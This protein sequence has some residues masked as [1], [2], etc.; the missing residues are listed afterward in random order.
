MKKFRILIVQDN[1]TYRKLLRD[2]LRNSFPKIAIDEAADGRET[3]QKLN[4]PF[5]NLI[6]MDIRLPDENG[7]EL[8][9]RIKTIHPGIRIVIV[10]GYDTA[11]YREAASK[12]GADDFFSKDSF[13]SAKIQDLIKSYLK[14]PTK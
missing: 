14:S 3:V 4:P 13:G 7:L 6:L 5:P 2:T 12:N 9:K 11:E 8:T 1:D 10:T